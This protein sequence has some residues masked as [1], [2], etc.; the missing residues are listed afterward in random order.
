MAVFFAFRSV[1]TSV[2]SSRFSRVG[3]FFTEI[4][5]QK[6]LCYQFLGAGPLGKL[7]LNFDMMTSGATV[8]DFIKAIPQLRI[9]VNVACCFFFL[10]PKIKR[11]T[12]PAS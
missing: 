8:D 2:K 6:I 3:G 12:L 11:F 1:S 9:S 10:Q 5:G 7:Q 4:G